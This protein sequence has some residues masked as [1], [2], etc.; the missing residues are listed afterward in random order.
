[1][2]IKKVMS[3]GHFQEYVESLLCLI[4]CPY[5]DHANYARWLSSTHRIH[6]F[7]A[8]HP[9][10]YKEFC[11]EYFVAHKTHLPLSVIALDQAHEQL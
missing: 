11:E 10:L 7:A 3:G 8:M 9:S 5:L 1:M 4:S 2:N 6:N